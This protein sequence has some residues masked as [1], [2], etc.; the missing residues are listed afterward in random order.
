MADLIVVRV[1][2][3]LVRVKQGAQVSADITIRNRTEEVGHYLLS[4]EGL[5]AGWAEIAP[6]QISAFPMQDVQS[7][8]VI[9]PPLDARGAT[10]HAA[11]RAASQENTA[12][13]VRGT[14]DIEVPVQTGSARPAPPPFM[15]E[16]HASGGTAANTGPTPAQTPRT[17]TAAQIEVIAELLKDSKLPPPTVQWRLSLHNAGGVIDTFAFSITGVKAAWVKLEPAQLT[18]KSDERASALLTVTPA[19]DTPAGAYPLILRAFSHLNMKQRTELPLKFEVRSAAGFQ[20]SID[21]KD[22]E[23]QGQRDF[24]VVLSSSPTSN[25]DL[26]LNLSASDQ[27]NACDYSFEQ[28]QV[29]VPAKQTVVSTLRARPRTTRGPNERKVYTI[30][31]TASERSGAVPP[32]TAEARLTQ[33]AAAPLRLVLHPQVMSGEL[34]ADFGLQAVNPSGVEASVVLAGDDPEGECEFSFTPARLTLPAGVESQARVKLKARRNFE[35]EGQKEHLFTVSVTRVGELEPMAT[36]QGRFQQK[37][38]RPVTLTLIPPQLSSTGAASYVL[39]ATN[40]RPRPVQVLLSAQDEADAL[41]F[42]FKPSE[43]NLSAGA[44]GSATLSARPKDRLMKGEQRRVHKFTVTGGVDGAATPP[45]AK[46]TLAQIP[47]IDLTGPAGTSLKLATWALRWSA[48]LLILLFLVTQ[49]L[50]GI[51]VVE[52]DCRVMVKGTA[53]PASQAGGLELDTPDRQIQCR[54]VPLVLAMLR[55][56]PQQGITT[57]VNLSPFSYMTR[58]IAQQLLDFVDVA[59]GRTP[60]RR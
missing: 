13:E 45:T 57:L 31:V 28:P 23:A 3:A 25:I 56:M 46:G 60:V 44:E 10:Y 14:L 4:V 59:S 30:K 39:R 38:L 33:V 11:V 1:E 18:L 17:Q 40:P 21:P 58:T 52:K 15:P 49:F 34:E 47:G 50:A 35:G 51:E 12:L 26:W 6:D 24:R 8:V 22:A 29:L 36:V 42:S 16:T 27:D 9:H 54:N 37:Q 48:V 20:L 53:I 41:A 2:P 55:V 43:I 32:Q 19:T 5:P 7:K